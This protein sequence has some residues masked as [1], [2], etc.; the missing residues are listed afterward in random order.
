MIQQI[1]TRQKCLWLILLFILLSIKPIMGQYTKM[2]VH[3][4]DG[5]TMLFEISDI[6]ELT[7]SGITGIGEMEKVANA[8][9]FFELIKTYPNPTKSGTTIEYRIDEPGLVKVCIYSQQGVLVRELLN[10]NLPAGEY[11]VK[12]DTGEYSGG[13]AD[14]GIYLCTIQFNNQIQSK[15]II[16]IN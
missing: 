12:W 13:K 1:F 2:V 3:K 6:Q 5:T 4:T 9:R 14:A 8:S 7:F 15:H 11:T 16:V 10:K